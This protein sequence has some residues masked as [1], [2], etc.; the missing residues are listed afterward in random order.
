MQM[1]V[2]EVYVADD[3]KYSMFAY[4]VAKYCFGWMHIVSV[5]LI[6]LAMR[7]DIRKAAADAYVKG[8]DDGEITFEQLQEH[9]GI[10]VEIG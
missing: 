1:Y 9:V 4:M 5:P 8:T 2:T 7:R 10:G 6:I 3:E